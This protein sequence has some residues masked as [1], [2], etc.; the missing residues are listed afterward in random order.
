VNPSNETLASDEGMPDLD[1]LSFD[2]A[3]ESTQG[4]MDTGGE[5]APDSAGGTVLEKGRVLL[6]EDDSG[7]RQIISEF[8]AGNGYTVVAVPT[9]GEGVREVLSANFTLILCDFMMPGLPGDMF[10]RAVQR[11]RPSLCQRFVFMTGHQCDARTLAFIR[12]VDGFVLQK[13]FPLQHLLDSIA[14]AETRVMFQ[15]VFDG[16]VTEL[17]PLPRSESASYFQ[18]GSTAVA[19]AAAMEKILARI[20]RNA[21]PAAPS[22]ATRDVKSRLR[23]AGLAVAIALLIPLLVLLVIQWSHYRDA[24][25]SAADAAAK[26]EANE[27]ELTTVSQD[28]RTAIAARPRIEAERRK[29]EQIAGNRAIPP[30]SPG[31]RSLVP[32]WDADIE[33][34][35]VRAHG[36]MEDLGAC[37]VSVRGVA[38]GAQPRLKA[39]QFRQAVEVGLMKSA[40]GFLATARV[41][42]IEDL[43]GAA[44]DQNRAAFFII[45]TVDP[46]IPPVVPGKGGS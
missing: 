17:N 42:Q 16:P 12:S 11:I 3:H 29:L 14:F 31:L 8:L 7:F 10:F 41:E 43:A 18:A 19:E 5:P 26:R 9:G 2:S 6:L 37:K 45:A 36:Q 32:A 1:T 39:E 28:L 23:V 27:A 24:R 44:A 4:A 21:L 46:I 22:D 15:S 40:P 33:I 30:W 34:L 13:P 25:D 35:E 20:R 38:G